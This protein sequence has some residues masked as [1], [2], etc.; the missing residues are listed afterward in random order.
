[1]RQTRRR[2]A[3]CLS[4]RNV[5]TY[6][7]RT[8]RYQREPATDK[9]CT[10]SKDIIHSTTTQIMGVGRGP[11]PLKCVKGVSVCFDPQNVTF[12]HYTTR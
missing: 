12:F 1:M 6:T 3:R 2:S 5:S 9:Q 8:R 7:S 4:S 11:D 10:T